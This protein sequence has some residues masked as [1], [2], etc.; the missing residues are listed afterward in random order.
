MN[1]L[2]FLAIKNYINSVHELTN[3]S[4]IPSLISVSEGR[5]LNP[6]TRKFFKRE[7]ETYAFTKLG[8]FIY[9]QYQL[10]KK[11]LDNNPIVLKIQNPN[12][13]LMENI[14]PQQIEL[15]DILSNGED[16]ESELEIKDTSILYNEISKFFWGKKSHVRTK[17]M[18]NVLHQ[19]SE[20][21]LK[22]PSKEFSTFFN[23][24]SCNATS[25]FK[26]R[27]NDRLKKNEF[28]FLPCFSSS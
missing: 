8:E 20:N 11:Y 27:L 5:I 17:Q 10:D 2:T 1:K 28:C 6:K 9:N 15:L 24:S 21:K 18:I 22:I 23:H 12:P 3:L 7:G 16:T 25:N 14:L 19:F 4:L 13:I 26:R